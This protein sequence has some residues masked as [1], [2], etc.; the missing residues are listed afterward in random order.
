MFEMTSQT[1]LMLGAIIVGSAY[2]E[3]LTA[4]NA[5]VTSGAISIL[6]AQQV[7]MMVIIM[8]AASTISSN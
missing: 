7:M 1:K 5:S 8:T 2:G 6:I 4:A 3:N